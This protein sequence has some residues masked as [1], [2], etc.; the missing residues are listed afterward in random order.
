MSIV[1]LFSLSSADTGYQTSIIATIGILSLF[2]ITPYLKLM[3]S[4]G[5]KV[6]TVEKLADLR[7]A[8]I[9]VGACRHQ[10]QQKTSSHFRS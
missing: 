1:Y 10:L 3:S 5:P 2:I 7:R 4:S 9:N 6:N 8:G